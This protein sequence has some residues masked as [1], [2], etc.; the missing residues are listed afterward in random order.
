M[1]KIKKYKIFYHHKAHAGM[2]YL[3]LED[4][5]NPHFDFHSE[6]EANLLLDILRNEKPVYYDPKDEII[7][8]GYEP[9]GEEEA[10]KRRAPRKKKTE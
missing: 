5:E 6:R 3:E 9:V 10:V 4:G 8:T 7:A 1:K 2:I